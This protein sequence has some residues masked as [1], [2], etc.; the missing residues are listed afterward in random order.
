MTWMR[1]WRRVD[2]SYSWGDSGRSTDGFDVW[3]GKGASEGKG[4]SFKGSLEGEGG[5]V[6]R[7]GGGF[8]GEG[9]G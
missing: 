2:D 8:M 5:R 6:E 4:G 1:M 7:L 3:I 9:M